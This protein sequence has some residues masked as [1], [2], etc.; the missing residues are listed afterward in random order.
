MSQGAIRSH[1][2]GGTS[3][4]STNPSKMCPPLISINVLKLHLNPPFTVSDCF[5]PL[6]GRTR[7]QSL[8]SHNDGEGELVEIESQANVLLYGRNNEDPPLLPSVGQEIDG[9]TEVTLEN[10]PHP[11]V[12]VFP[13]AA[14]DLMTRLPFVPDNI[15]LIVNPHESWIMSVIVMVAGL[16]GLTLIEPGVPTTPTKPAEPA[17]FHYNAHICDKDQGN[18]HHRER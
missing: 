10:L 17:P 8:L 11:L 12:N 13:Q 18:H 3:A 4:T 5:N 14:K 2:I 15:S 7:L 9:N 16:K 6:S 1:V